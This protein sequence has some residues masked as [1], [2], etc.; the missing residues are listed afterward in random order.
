MVIAGVGYLYHRRMS[1]PSPISASVPPYAVA[2]ASRAG[3]AGGL[4]IYA[5]AG[6]SLSQP[7][8]LPTGARL[9][10][11]IHT[12]LTSAFPVLATVDSADLVAVADA[13]A[14]LPGGQEALSQTSARSANF[15]TARPG[16][17]HKVLAHLMLEGAI[18]VLTTNWDT[19]IERGAGEE[20]LP[21]VTNDHDLAA[22]T[23]PWV[24]KVHGCASRP[25]SLLVTSGQLDSPPTWVQEQTRARLGMAVVVFIGIGDVAGYVRQRI[26]E[27]IHEVGSVQNIR[28]VAPD[29]ETNWENSQWK[30][31]APSLN[32]DDKIPATADLFMEQLAA[33]YVIRR[34]GEHSVTVSSDEVLAAD[35]EAAKV[36]LLE[37]DSLTV[38]QWARSVDINPRVGEAV[39]KSSELGK[40]MIA[41]GHLAGDSARLKHNHIFDTAKGPV[42]V[43]IATQT[44]PPRHLVEAAENRLSD[45]ASRGE[46][47]PLFIVAGGVGPIPKTN[48]LPGSILGETDVLDI[49]YGPLARVPDVRHADDVIAS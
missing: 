5:G 9:A 40:V 13:V 33:A 22:V 12:Q 23:P 41:L 1:W 6:I 34:L 11:A 39:L 49:V 15:K 16:Y 18:D 4:V 45:H 3:S 25:D 46:Q 36:G 28:V 35:L 29:I 42:E 43:L 10:A 26:E 17:A 2:L 37:S 47:L 32:D 27:A 24:L 8:N 30:T 48:S 7:T 19:C 38:L 20:S 21:T 44:V 14:A 31:V